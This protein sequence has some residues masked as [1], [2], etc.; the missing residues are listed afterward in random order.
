MDCKIY[1]LHLRVSS[2]PEYP[3]TGNKGVRSS[4]DTRQVEDNVDSHRTTPCSCNLSRAVLSENRPFLFIH[5]VKLTSTG[6]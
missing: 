4:E 6:E 2:L 3:S 1:K 5:Q